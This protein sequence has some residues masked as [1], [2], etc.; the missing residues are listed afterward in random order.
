MSISTEIDLLIT[1]MIIFS[2]LDASFP[3]KVAK[4][5]KIEKKSQMTEYI[6]IVLSDLVFVF[7]LQVLQSTSQFQA[8][9]V[10]TGVLLKSPEVCLSYTGQLLYRLAFQHLNTYCRQV[11]IGS[12][13]HKSL[14]S[15]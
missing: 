6:E 11:S 12:A 10:L 13:F 4:N 15:F 8:L 14:I 9:L 2:R 7:S 5:F 3:V 1:N